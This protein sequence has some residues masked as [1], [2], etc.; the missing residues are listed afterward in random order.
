MQPALGRLYQSPFLGQ[1]QLL[2]VTFLW[3]SQALPHSS[4]PT[5]LLPFPVTFSPK[6]NQ[7]TYHIPWEEAE[8]ALPAPSG[9]WAAGDRSHVLIALIFLVGGAQSRHSVTA[10]SVE[11]LDL[12]LLGADRMHFQVSKQNF[13]RTKVLT[14]AV[15]PKSKTNKKELR[16]F[17]LSRMQRNDTVAL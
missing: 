5:L 13:N 15:P 3:S 7:Y 2:Q 12:K 8:L 14:C 6:E 16:W 4:G 17:R 9:L 10:S 11:K 1:L